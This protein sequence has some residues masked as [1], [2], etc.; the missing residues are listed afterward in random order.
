M[1]SV[2]L[3]FELTERGDE[4]LLLTRSY[5]GDVDLMSRVAD[6]ANQA[7]RVLLNAVRAHNI[8]VKGYVDDD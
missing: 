6:P 5:E 4:V 7:H 8:G 1:T 2:K 3:I